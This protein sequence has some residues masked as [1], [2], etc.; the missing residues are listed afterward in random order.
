MANNIDRLFREGLDQFEVTPSA[1]SWNEVKGQIAGKKN[2]GLW[3]PMSVAAAVVLL[4]VASILVINADNEIQP[5]PRIASI[6]HPVPQQ[7]EQLRVDVTQP[8]QKLPAS[9]LNVVAKTT[10]VDNQP[11]IKEQAVDPLVYEEIAIA[12]IH[13]LKLEVDMPRLNLE[14]SIK[15]TEHN[16]VTQIKITYIAENHPDS[17]KL[18]L[19]NIFASLSEVSPSE[20]L[21]DIRDVKDNL[22]SKN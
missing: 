11:S 8:D 12:S 1:Q 4:V 6:D 10:Q 9:Q 16:S 21:A 19:G 14:N 5:G 3:I 18:K 22:F 2:K 20:F 17:T 7:I 13:S 15:R